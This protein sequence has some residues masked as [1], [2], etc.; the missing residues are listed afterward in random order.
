MIDLHRWLAE[1]RDYHF[2]SLFDIIENTM[3][4]TT[5]TQVG[6]SVTRRLLCRSK[7]MENAIIEIVES[8]L[9]DK[10]WEGL[11]YLMGLEEFTTFQPIYVGKAEKKGVTAPIS[12]N[13]RNIRRNEHKFARWGDG[14]DYHIGDLSQTL[15]KFKGYR[16]PTKKY[17]RWAR[18]LFAT[19]DPPVLRAKVY[20][21]V[22]PWFNGM[23][24]PSGLVC[25]LPAVEKEL[26][27]LAS[28]SSRGLLLNVDGV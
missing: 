2:V 16:E 12:A 24:G 25:S 27:S 14:L 7:S 15:F 9:K 10:G 8:G 11:F 22:A 1:V 5:K 19:R 6:R 23:K 4:V 28:A 18:L 17:E 26:I 3:E 20:F 21:Y 13:I